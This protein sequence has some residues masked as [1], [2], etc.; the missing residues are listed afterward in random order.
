M[1]NL[2][3]GDTIYFIGD[4]MN[5]SIHKEEVR[6]ICGNVLFTRTIDKNGFGNTYFFGDIEDLETFGWKKYEPKNK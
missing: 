2:K 4:D 3:T 5:K 1:K 6:G